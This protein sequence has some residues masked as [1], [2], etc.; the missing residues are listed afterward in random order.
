MS[1]VEKGFSLIELMIVVTVMILLTGGSVAYVNRYRAWE[2]IRTTRDEL[3][4]NLVLARNYAKTL[5]KPDG[6][7]GEVAYVAVTLTAGGVL[8]AGMNGVGTTYFSRDIS[9]SGVA[10]STIGVNDLW[11]SAYDGK[12]VDLNGPRES[13]YTVGVMIS[14]SEGIGNTTGVTVNAFGLIEQ[15]PGSPGVD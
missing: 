14:S 9:P 6:A 3:E 2:K 10:V 1:K 7:T 13:S 12:L 11:F 8:T 15:R 4:T 5:Q